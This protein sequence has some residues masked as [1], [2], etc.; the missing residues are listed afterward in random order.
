[1]RC[2]RGW[3]EHWERL[4]RSS[5][6]GR[7]IVGIIEIIEIALSSP[8]STTNRPCSWYLVNGH[9]ERERERSVGVC[10]IG[11]NVEIVEI[12]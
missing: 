6:G 9:E 7:E 12:V 5:G 10:I 8:R 4:W 2:S 3:R 1:M 11:K